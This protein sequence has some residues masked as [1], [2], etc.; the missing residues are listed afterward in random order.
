[1]ALLG[2]GGMADNKEEEQGATHTMPDGTVMPGATHQ[3]GGDTGSGMGMGIGNMMTNLSNSMFEG[4]SQEDVYRMGQGFNTLRFEP[5][6]QMAANFESRLGK[7]SENRLV[8]AKNNDTIAYLRTLK[9]PEYPNGRQD[10][11]ELI[12]DGLLPATDALNE[13]RTVKPSTALEQKLEMYRDPTLTDKER[14]FLFPAASKSDFLTKWDILHDPANIDANGELLLSDGEI[15]L[16]GISEPAVYKQQIADLDEKLKNK[17]ITQEE[18]KELSLN[19]IAGMTPDDGKTDKYR[20]L[21]MVAT[22]RGFSKGSEEWNKFFDVNMAGDSINVEVGDTNVAMDT[23]ESASNLYLKEYM[24]QYI[25]DSTKIMQDVDTAKTQ[26]EKLGNLLDI[27]EADDGVDG[28]APYT[29]IFQPFLTQATRVVTS[30]GIDKKYASEIEAYKNSTGDDKTKAR[31]ILYEKLVKTEITK[32]MTGSDVFP[33]ISS[34]GIGA[35]GLDTPAERDFLI[36]VMT[37]LPNMTIDTLKY[38]TKFRLQMYIDGLEKY[39]AKVDSGYFKMHNEN[40]NLPKRGKID[41][42]PLR[43]YTTT[44]TRIVSEDTPTYTQDEMNLIFGNMN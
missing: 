10:L 24:P 30:L 42:E 9:S 13:A 12:E 3:G 27:L 17:E 25:K 40:P 20:M 8:T 44:G 1:M 22:D 4:M 14:A 37:G 23:P 38:M 26:V 7:I 28:V 31:D 15:Q 41:I 19:V 5:D 39:N 6:A 29:G 11:I 21:E 32:V 36:S 18:Y 2:L 35:R 16:M 33:M 43:R 34:L